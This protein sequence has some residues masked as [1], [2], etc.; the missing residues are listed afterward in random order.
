M[1]SLSNHEPPLVLRHPPEAGPP[2]AGAQDERLAS[3]TRLPAAADGD[4]ALAAWPPAR[5]GQERGRGRA[6]SE[7]KARTSY[8]AARD[9][10]EKKRR[11]DLT[12]TYY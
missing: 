10:V 11:G 1:V 8:R 9:V 7:A 3:A 2:Q 6:S 12:I 5:K 4:G